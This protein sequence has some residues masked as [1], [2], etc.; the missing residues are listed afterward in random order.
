MSTLFHSDIVGT[1]DNCV[2]RSRLGSR[3][4]RRT[5]LG[6]GCTSGTWCSAGS[7]RDSSRKSSRPTCRGSRGRRRTVGP[8]DR[9]SGACSHSRAWTRTSTR[10]CCSRA[11]WR[12]RSR[13]A[14]YRVSGGRSPQWTVGSCVCTATSSRPSRG[15][16]PV[17]TPAAA[18]DRRS[19]TF[20]GN[21]LR[22]PDLCG[23][24][25]R[26][27]VIRTWRVYTVLEFKG[28]SFLKYILTYP[29]LLTIS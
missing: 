3:P 21:I 14:V 13:P 16:R 28:V 26:K 25:N 6:P 11:T 9:W 17:C 8:T 27:C 22:P 2:R 24:R 29:F 5:G 19:P 20:S 23:H 10:C 4:R 15:S 1:H 7:R 18:A 12:S